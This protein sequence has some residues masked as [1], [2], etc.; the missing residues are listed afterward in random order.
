VNKNARVP[1]DP[2]SVADPVSATRV[3]VGAMMWP[4]IATVFGQMLFKK[5]RNN[6]RRTMLG[7]TGFV[8]IKGLLKL[9]YKQQQYK[10]QV[11]RQVMDYEVALR[12]EAAKQEANTEGIV[13]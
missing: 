12:L 2:A 11:Q 5:Q 3:M 6:F 1:A 9:Y 10:R 7:G 8:L 4:T 13:P